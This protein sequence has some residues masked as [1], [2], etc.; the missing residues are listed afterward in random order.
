MK[1]LKLLNYLMDVWI[2]LAL[3]ESSC[4]SFFLVKLK[5]R[6]FYKK[7]VLM[8]QEYSKYPKIY[9]ILLYIKEFEE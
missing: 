1:I 2:I 7:K 5:L 8:K 3:I 9:K 6:V 4:V